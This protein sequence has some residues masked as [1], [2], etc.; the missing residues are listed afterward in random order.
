MKRKILCLML[1][2]LLALSGCTSLLNHDYVDVQPHADRPVTEE[3]S[4]IVRVETYKQLMDGIYSFVQD[5]QTRGV[6]HIANYKGRTNSTLEADLAAA[7]DE[8]KYEDALGAYCVDYIRYETSYIVSYYEADIYISY[9]RTRDQ[10][11]SI[12]T[13]TGSSAIREEL[14]GTLSSF[15]SEAVLQV[16]YFN[17][18]ESYIRGLIHQAYYDTPMAAMGMPEIDI[19]I[20]PN[21]DTVQYGAGYP[22]IVEIL[23]TY[24]ED[25][26]TLRKKS[27]ALADHAESLA[28][29]L[30]ALHGEEAAWEAFDQLRAQTL[31]IPSGGAKSPERLNTTYAAA[32]EGRADSEGMALA[33]QLYCQLAGVECTVVSGAVDGAAHYWNIIALPGG[34]YRH[35]DATREDG[36]ALHDADLAALAYAWD[37]KEYPACGNQPI[38]EGEQAPEDTAAANPDG[39]GLTVPSE[40]SGDFSSDELPADSPVQSASPQPSATFYVG[41][42]NAP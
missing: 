41:N 3:D 4:S 38:P 14:Q 23:L 19:S 26:E 6:I 13:V 11:K 21:S 8:V 35:V 39:S 29:Q 33:F 20:Y 17:E 37:R 7:C 40:D 30:A 18:D 16:S 25:Q 24:P 10:V 28:P 2:G 27:V 42:K 15:G 5:G 22:R 12:K 31:Y 9:R 32:V 34:E 1:T 36:F